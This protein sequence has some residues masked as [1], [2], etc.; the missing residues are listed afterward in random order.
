MGIKMFIVGIVVE[1]HMWS[2][3][4]EDGLRIDGNIFV[5][6]LILKVVS[7]LGNVCVSN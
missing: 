6:G 2:L 5:I 7:H 1:C 4:N 3:D